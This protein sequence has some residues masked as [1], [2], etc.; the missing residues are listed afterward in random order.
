MSEKISE[1]IKRVRKKTGLNTK[2]FGQKIGKSA[3]TIENWEQG[4]YVPH[5]STLKFVESVFGDMIK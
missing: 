2:N 5:S 4:A 3:K 1:Y